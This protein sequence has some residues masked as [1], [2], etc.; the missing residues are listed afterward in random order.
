VVVDEVQDLTN[1]ELSLVLAMLNEPNS[2]LLCGDA[3]QIVHPNFFS[4]SSVK[5]LFYSHEQA[6]LSAP[7]HVL[8]ANY[9]SSRAICSIANQLLKIKNARFSSIDRE[10]TALVRAAADHE[11]RIVGLVKKDGVLRE[12]DQR[13]RGSVKVAVIVLSDEH[14]LE[15][16][17]RFAT[18]LVFS[19]HEAKG[20]EYEAVILFDIV[21]SERVRFREVCEGVSARDLERDELVYARPRDKSDKSLEVYKFF[22]NALYVA[23]T[24]AVDTLYVVES[25]AEHLLLSMLGVRLGEDTSGVATQKSSREEWQK[26]A[27]RLELQGKAEQAAAIRSNILRLTPVP[28]PVIDAAELRELHNKAL[29]PRSIFTK[30]KQRLCEFAAFNEIGTLVRD[31]KYRAH[32]TSPKPAEELGPALR[33]RAMAHYSAK[34]PDKVLMEVTRHGLEHR[35]MFGMT[36]LMMAA[37]AGNVSLV[38][39]LLERGARLDAGDSLGRMPVH[40]ALRRAF[41]DPTFAA[42]RLGPLYALLCPTSIDIEVDDR[43]LRLGKNQGEFLLLLFLVARFH[44]LYRGLRRYRGFGTAM[45]GEESLAAFP[46]SVVP[47]ERRR[48][49]YWNGVLARAEVGSS[50]RPARKLWRRERTGH[51]V[52]SHIKIRVAGNEGDADVYVPL[53]KLL[54]LDLLEPELIVSAAE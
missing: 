49:T 1:A 27:R 9:R 29:A 20:L 39:T 54:G 30:S 5:S 41:S 8:E 51:Y 26:E 28:W 2:F 34:T 11:G 46:R 7:V 4:W 42:E 25:D 32:Y 53:W 37:D 23:M 43:R 10:S 47:E 40:F 6:A 24:R 16:K 31:L 48:R 15:A 38:E 52:P 19:V 50:Y 13:T 45:I 36:P 33:E 17:K 21:S 22:V 18:P 12:L 44:H 3:N 14:K 35:N